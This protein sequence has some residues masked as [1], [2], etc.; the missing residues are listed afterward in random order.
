[1]KIL[2]LRFKNIHSLKGEHEIDFTKSPFTESGLFAITG[3][4]G[5]GKSTILDV[6]TLSLFS[7]IPRFDGKI[8][9][10]EIEKIGSVMTHFT[11]DAYAEIEYQCK[12]KFY[13]ST[14]N[15]SK[16]SKGKLKDYNMLLSVFDDE[17]MVNGSYIG[18]K[19]SMVPVENENIIGLNYEQF[20]RSILLSQ[21]EFAKFLR[22]DEKERAKLLEDIT[23][24][25][26]YRIIGKKVFEKAKAKREEIALIS[27]DIL[28]IPNLS[29][30]QISEKNQQLR[31]NLVTIESHKNAIVSLTAV[32]NMLQKREELQKKL[33]ILQIEQKSI[34]ENKVSFRHK[35]VMWEKHQKL[36][37]Y[38]N[39]IILLMNESQRL[40]T[41]SKE[42]T[43]LNQNIENQQLI[44]NKLLH[45]ISIFVHEEVNK[46]NVTSVLRKF[47]QK[48]LLLDNSLSQVAE[49]GKKLRNRINTL[50]SN[51]QNNNFVTTLVNIKNIEEQLQY[52]TS[53]LD[54]LSE[55]GFSNLDD[56]GLKIKL[57]ENK[58]ELDT[59]KLKH[60]DALKREEAMVTIT[61][62]SMEIDQ[63]KASKNDLEK[64][65]GEINDLLNNLEV[66][67]ATLEKKKEEDIKIISLDTH[68]N[69]LVDGQPCPLCGAL[70]H[71]YA[72]EKQLMAL[73][74]AEVALSQKVNLK[75]ENKSEHTKL[76]AQNAVIDERIVLLKKQVEDK[77]SIINQIVKK[78][79]IVDH[80]SFASEKIKT[81]IESFQNNV[82][83]LSKE[84]NDRRDKIFLLECSDML[85]EIS[86]V[87]FQYKEI[88]TQKDTIYQ[89]QD[90]SIDVTN[91][92]KKYQAAN[93]SLTSYISNKNNLNESVNNLSLSILNTNQT[94]Q[95]ILKS[96]GYESITDAQ[97]DIID[98]V[99]VQNILKQK[100]DLTKAETQN[101]TNIKSVRSELETIQVPENEETD[102]IIL[103][104]NIGNLTI[105]KDQLLTSIGGINRELE[106][107]Q[108]NKTAIAETQVR[109]KK[110]EDESKKW[111]IL[112]ELI[113]DANG[114]N[115][116][117]F[118]Q[119]L[120]LKHLITLANK[121]LVK[122]TD[123]YLLASSDIEADLTIIDL[124]QGSVQRSVKTLSG[125]ESFLV[126]LAMALSLSDMASK[127]VKLESLFID[128]GFGSLDAETLETALETLERL[129]SES[130]KMI[131]VIS[132][133]ESMKERITTQIRVKKSNQGYSVIEV[134]V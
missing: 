42:K 39:D 67:I 79:Q 52:V 64:R 88:K 54:Q 10:T 61:N 130:N 19:K 33:E 60:N 96:L 132:H 12:D 116:S 38:R 78:W 92:E 80:E 16:T 84:E 22:S 75:N 113:G 123:R 126:S 43:A 18:E 83:I 1:M 11:E 2:K 51:H 119:N 49:E 98:E 68:R 69:E 87:T 114:N 4:T 13:R 37:L 102:I 3:P 50:C 90:I 20:V 86:K 94:L 85:K 93:E 35:E 5:A 134:K 109:L 74:K 17:S 55:N 122:L 25:Q 111:I 29:D 71:P 101:D 27:R 9:N 66:E 31:D 104:E 44:I 99:T 95:P 30:E 58:A 129:Q 65:L 81:N 40:A 14:W 103:R 45:D 73:G 118:A 110:A 36:G 121:R 56:N 48:V 41:L 89:G 46:E 77:N 21:G 26:I 7:R 47:E 32:L 97:K 120:S 53:S 62:I 34:L 100:E 106:H 117:K 63:S 127:N 125:G 112:N 28:A 133:V 6:I 59:L 57:A 91:Y 15:I 8:T 82:E 107:D 124:Y 128:E 105:E 131:G 70:D 108:K 76:I 72:Y 23:G 115:F 24:S